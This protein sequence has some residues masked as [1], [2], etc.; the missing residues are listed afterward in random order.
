MKKMHFSA[1][2]ASGAAD[3][4]VPK[5][6]LPP[7]SNNGLPPW[8]DGLYAAAL[9]RIADNGCSLASLK[10][11]AEDVGLD[12]WVAQAYWPLGVVSLLQQL[13]QDW[14]GQFATLAKGLD[15]RAMGTT[16]RVRTLLLARL[17]M[18]APHYRLLQQFRRAAMTQPR[19]AWHM[20]QGVWQASSQLWYL[21]GDRATDHNWYSKRA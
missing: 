7:F 13:Q 18:L 5:D 17:E 1:D 11:A 2:A 20:Q 3:S 12:W 9:A 14:Q 21:A 15:L 10:L 8:P 6:G 4:A 16:A 19:L